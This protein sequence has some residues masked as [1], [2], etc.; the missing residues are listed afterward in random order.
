MTFAPGILVF[1]KRPRWESELKR[2]LAGRDVVIRP[3]RSGADA[4]SLLE[5]MPGSVLVLELESGPEECLRLVAFAAQIRQE[6]RAVV[7]GPGDG[8]ELE[9][10]LRELGAGGVVPAT[11]PARELAELCTRLLVETSPHGH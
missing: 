6:G 9:W 4:R 7:I 10:S 3:C 11:V 8:A 2:Q 5:T 1:E